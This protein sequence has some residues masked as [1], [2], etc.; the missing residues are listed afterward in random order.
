[1]N[2]LPS[3]IQTLANT[4]AAFAMVC[5]ALYV[6][7]KLWLKAEAEKTKLLMERGDTKKVL[8]DINE[9][10]NELKTLMLKK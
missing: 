6:V 8:D 4:S 10:L 3:S 7:F 2:E 1:M 5:I 9:E